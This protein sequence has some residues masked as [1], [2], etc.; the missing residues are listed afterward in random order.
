MKHADHVTGV[1]VC[2]TL[3]GQLPTSAVGMQS[4]LS[5]VGRYTAAAVAS[6]ACGETVAVVDGNVTRVVARLRAIGAD[7]ADK[8]TVEMLWELAQDIL[9]RQRPG[10]A[11]QALMELGATV[12]TPK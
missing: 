10:D 7:V 6:I 1:Q 5:G 11:N 3:G 12:C 8:R 9:D 2:N 4:Q